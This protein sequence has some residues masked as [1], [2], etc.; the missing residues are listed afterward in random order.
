MIS[1]MSQS[2]ECLPERSDLGPMDHVCV[3][4]SALHFKGEVVAPHGLSFYYCC[5]RGQ[6]GMQPLPEPPAYIKGLLTDASPDARHFRNQIG[7]YNDAMA[8]TACIYGKSNRPEH[9]H[10]LVPFLIR[11][12]L[13]HAHF[14]LEHE[15]GSDAKY[16]QAYLYEP[17]AASGFRFASV[18]GGEVRQR[19]LQQLHECLLDCG[20]PFIRIYQ[21]AKEQLDSVGTAPYRLAITPQLNLVIEQ[22]EEISLFR[23][24]KPL[25][26][27]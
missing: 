5:V 12:E 26:N 1:Y 14:P 2:P 24:T 22:G 23:P 21:T 27:S 8:F 13:F 16:A 18:R 9:Q 11:G 3:H 10:G 19:V 25:R 17:E 6:S 20:N 15:L 4:C 7:R